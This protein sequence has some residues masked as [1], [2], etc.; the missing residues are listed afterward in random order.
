M[1]YGQVLLIPSCGVEEL[2]HCVH[3]QVVV[4]QQL[5]RVSRLLAFEWPRLQQRYHLHLLLLLCLPLY[6]QY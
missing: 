4:L 6:S 2:R 3:V 1:Q 5:L